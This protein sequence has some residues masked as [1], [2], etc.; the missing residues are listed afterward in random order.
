VRDLRAQRADDR[1]GDV[2]G[3]QAVAEHARDRRSEALE[4]RR[5]TGPRWPGGIQIATDSQRSVTQISPNGSPSA[6]A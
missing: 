3:L 2:R 6:W 4:Q 5:R 1:L